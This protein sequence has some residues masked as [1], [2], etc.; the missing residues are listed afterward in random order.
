MNI[1]LTGHKGYVGS[2]LLNMMDDKSVVCSDLK[3]GRDFVNITGRIFDVVIHLAAHASV[4]ESLK[5][6]DE[7]LDNNAFKI[8][9]FLKNNKVG[10]FIFAS[11]G[12]AMYGDKL[13]AKESDARYSNELSPYG[14][15]KFLAEGIIRRMQLNHIILRLGNVY[16][17]ND[18]DRQEAAVHRHFKIDNPIVV[19]G[20]P[21]RDFIAV[22]D[23][24]QAFIRAI[25]LDVT[26]TFNIS[27]GKETNVLILAKTYSSCRYVP[28]LQK[29]WRDG[30]VHYVS[31]NVTEARIAGLL[32]F[33]E[34]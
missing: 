17:G 11:T 7:C 34:Y 18:E 13:Q 19:Y 25:D 14:L 23:V 3:D 31:L 16:G 20:E 12:G 28:V 2:H 5:D 29:P 27:S 21:I 1:F 15:S 8:A 9:A 33:K 4:T 30:E 24:C 26:G 32:D 22:E 6:P 10:K